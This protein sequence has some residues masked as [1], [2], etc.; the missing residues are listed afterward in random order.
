MSLLLAEISLSLAG[1]ALSLVGTS[2]L[3]ALAPTMLNNDNFSLSKAI[4]LSALLYYVTINS[5][6]SEPSASLCVRII[7]KP[8]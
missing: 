2:L 6:E 4:V 1:W 3:E 7:F 5:V 8:S